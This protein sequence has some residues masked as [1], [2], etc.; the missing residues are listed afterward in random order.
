MS[1]APRRGSLGTLR[2]LAA[3]V[4]ALLLAYYGFMALMARDALWFVGGFEGTP[5]RLVIYDEGERR[6]LVPGDPGF[7]VVAAAVQAGLRQGFARL[8]KI[9]FSEASLQEAYT[10]Q[11]T[12]EVFFKEPVTLHTWFHTGRTTQML[13]PLTGRHAEMSLVLLGDTGE[14][15][16]GAPVLHTT[17][18]IREALRSLGTY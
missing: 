15:R 7:E 18:P 9:G 8:S 14:Y 10:Q 4:G 16:T 5:S 6:I 1:G 12:L 3:L 2:M 13:F 11:V 17:E